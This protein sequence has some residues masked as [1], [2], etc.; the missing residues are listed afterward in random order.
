MFTYKYT[1]F[2]SAAGISRAVTTCMM[3]IMTVSTLNFDEALMLMQYCRRPAGPNYGFR[4][5]LREYHNNTAA[6]VSYTV[7]IDLY[8]A[9]CY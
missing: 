7:F 8:I 1:L 2:C 5:Q 9:A 4:M 6:K 3:Y